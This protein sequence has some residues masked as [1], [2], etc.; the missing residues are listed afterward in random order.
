MDPGS[1]AHHAA[2]GGAL[3]STGGTFARRPLQQKKRPE[4]GAFFVRR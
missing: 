1:A 2:K 3:R 4:T